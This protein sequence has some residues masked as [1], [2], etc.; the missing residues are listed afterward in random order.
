MVSLFRPLVGVEHFTGSVTQVD[1]ESLAMHNAQEGLV[2]LKQYQTIFTCR[3]QPQLQML[4]LIHLADFLVRFGAPRVAQEAA[5][6]CLES[7][8]ESRVGYAVCGPL[9]ELFQRTLIECGIPILNELAE[10]ASPVSD[11][12]LD[13]VMDAC[14]RLSYTQPVEHIRR[15]LAPNIAEDWDREMIRLRVPSPDSSTSSSRRFHGDN[16]KLMQ[17]RSILNG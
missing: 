5:L 2:L 9:Q 17:I 8:K 16:D 12:C 7:L 3:Y 13:E 1:P 11:F 4:C 15:R 10:A 6:F 14:T